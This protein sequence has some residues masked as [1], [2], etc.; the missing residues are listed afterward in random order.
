MTTQLT[1]YNG[2]LLIL[3]ERS[4]ASLAESRESRR[5]LDTVWARPAVKDV[6]EMGLWNFATRSVEV[7]YSPS[8][9]PSFGYSHVFDRPTDIVRTVA[10][11]SDE[12]FR[13]PITQYMTEGPY[14]FANTTPIYVRYVSDDASYGNDLAAWPGNFTRLVEAYLADSIVIRLTN[15]KSEWQ[16][17]RAVMQKALQDAKNTDAM[18]QPTMFPPPGLWVRSRRGNGGSD[19]GNRGSLIG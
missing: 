11:C 10:L 12:E 7:E 6:L 13:I 9:S 3:G 16:R 15:D 17:V 5:L 4:L 1:L 8:V 18:E 19:R 2:A 14:W